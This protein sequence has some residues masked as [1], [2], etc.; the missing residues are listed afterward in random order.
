M[1]YPKSRSAEVKVAVIEQQ[2]TAPASQQQYVAIALIG[3][4]LLAAFAVG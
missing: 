2:A 1:R 3:L 4:S